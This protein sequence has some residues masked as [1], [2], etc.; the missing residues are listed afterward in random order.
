M[1]LESMQSQLS[2]KEKDLS[3]LKNLRT[4]LSS[5]EGHVNTISTALKEAAVSMEKAGTIDGKPF[6]KGKTEEY[7]IEYEKTHV[8]IE[9]AITSVKSDI[10]TLEQE[11]ESL[12]NDIAAEIRRL[13]AIQRKKEEEENNNN[14]SNTENNSSYTGYN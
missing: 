4:L 6:D 12:K 8:D 14:T 11:I 13:E 2:D 7:S 5:L 1:S 9:E 10:A 3:N